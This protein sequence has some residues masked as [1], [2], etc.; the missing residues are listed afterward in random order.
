[1]GLT[2][3][4]EEKSTME[5]RE[6]RARYISTGGNGARAMIEGDRARTKE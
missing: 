5:E 3:R 4:C 6:E 2:P 1:M